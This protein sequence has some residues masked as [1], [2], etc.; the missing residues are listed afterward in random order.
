MVLLKDLVDGECPYLFKRR[1]K[2][3]GGELIGM[4]L[5]ISKGPCPWPEFGCVGFKE[6]TKKVNA[7]VEA[8]YIDDVFSGCRDIPRGHL[9][10]DVDILLKSWSGSPLVD[11]LDGDRYVGE[12]GPQA[13]HP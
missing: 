11:E 1:R 6:F 3:D 10:D 4:I 2:Y 9:F 12:E 8:A 7:F 13:S 5:A